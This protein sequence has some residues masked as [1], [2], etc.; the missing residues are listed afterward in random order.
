[1][2][3]LHQTP[4]GFLVETGGWRFSFVQKENTDAFELGPSAGPDVPSFARNAF[5]DTARTA[6]LNAGHTLVV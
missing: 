6:M 5:E 2:P 1:M 4:Y 3:Q